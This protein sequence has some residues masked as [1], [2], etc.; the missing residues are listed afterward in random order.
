MTLDYI[1]VVV[2][3]S[4]A[5]SWSRSRSSVAPIK[6]GTNSVTVSVLLRQYYMYFSPTPDHTILYM[7]MKLLLCA[8]GEKV[9]R[10]VGGHGTT[11]SLSAYSLVPYLVSLVQSY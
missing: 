9:L 1:T 5:R 2:R 8:Q 3:G 10:I 4:G 6:H 7:Q 11:S